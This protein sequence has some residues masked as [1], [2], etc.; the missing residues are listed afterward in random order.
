LQFGADVFSWCSSLTSV[1]I[2][3][4]LQTVIARSGCLLL[5]AREEHVLDGRARDDVTSLVQYR[6]AIK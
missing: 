4:S 5:V 3:A 1:C 6:P 2:P